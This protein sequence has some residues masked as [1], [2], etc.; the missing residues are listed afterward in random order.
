MAAQIRTVVTNTF[1]TL[2]VSVAVVLI[3]YYVFNGQGERVSVGWFLS[4]T[5][6]YMW[7]CLGIGLSVSLSVVGAALGIHTTGTSIV[8]GGVKAPRIKT[9]NLI[10]VIFCEAVAIYGLITAIVLS[11]QLD[12]FQMS[13]VLNNQALQNSNWL[14]GYLIFGAGLAVG[15]VNLFCGI[16]VG[17]IGSG[18]ALSDAANAALFVKI[19]IVEIFGSAIGLFGLI[20]GIY[21]TSKSKMGDKE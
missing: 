2:F 19:L 10:S 1:L 9:K 11:G 5:S 8:G 16:A 4:T 7:A 12:Q 6:P 20:V 15:L 18:A 3:L 21:M 17:I 14:S 13:V